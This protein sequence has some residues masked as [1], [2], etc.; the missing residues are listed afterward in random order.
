MKKGPDVK[1]TES[2]GS[3][4]G[5]RMTPCEAHVAKPPLGLGR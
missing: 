1:K 4:L 5:Q 3:V 2:E